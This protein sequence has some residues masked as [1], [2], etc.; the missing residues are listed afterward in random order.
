MLTIVPTDIVILIFQTLD[1]VPQTGE[2]PVWHAVVFRTEMLMMTTCHWLPHV[3][4]FTAPLS[5][6]NVNIAI[7]YKYL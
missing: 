1:K 3:L 7:I 5:A 6:E 2:G 4:R